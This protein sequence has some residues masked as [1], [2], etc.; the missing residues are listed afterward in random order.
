[1][2][3]KMNMA[4][5]P[6]GSEESSDEEVERQPSGAPTATVLDSNLGSRQSSAQS[7]GGNRS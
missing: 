7:T 4:D 1:M 2:K 3:E 6:V 5:K